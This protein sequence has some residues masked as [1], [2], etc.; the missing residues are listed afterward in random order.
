MHT[1]N[2]I[3]H[4]VIKDRSPDSSWLNDRSANLCERHTSVDQVCKPTDAY[5]EVVGADRSRQK[6]RRGRVQLE[7]Q[8]LSLIFAGWGHITGT[9]VCIGCTGSL[10]TSEVEERLE[11]ETFA[12]RLAFG[13]IL[14]ASASPRP[15]RAWQSGQ[16]RRAP[17]AGDLQKQTPGAP[18][19]RCICRAIF[20]CGWGGGYK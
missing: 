7:A 4:R 11:R 6:G 5:S 1:Y 13:V 12:Q 8:R 14:I 2:T 19:L 3:L 9:A 10:L 17:I 18:P 15:A 20:V 16:P